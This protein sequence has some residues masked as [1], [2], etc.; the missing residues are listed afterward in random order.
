MVYTGKTVSI[1][2]P[3]FMGLYYKRDLCVSDSE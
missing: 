1:I 2:T 3:Y